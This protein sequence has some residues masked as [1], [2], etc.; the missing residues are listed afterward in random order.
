MA[1]FL[2]RKLDCLERLARIKRATLTFGGLRSIQLSYRRI[3]F[4]YNNLKSI[5]LYLFCLNKRLLQVFSLIFVYISRFCESK[6]ADHWTN[7]FIDQCGCQY[8]GYNQRTSAFG[9]WF[10]GEYRI[11]CGS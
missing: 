6:F 11:G 8:D 7:E 2:A 1:Y 4:F 10:R 3:S 5:I 9:F